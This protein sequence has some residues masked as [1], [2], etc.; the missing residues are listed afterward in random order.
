MVFTRL[1]T[2]EKE[3]FFGLLDEYFQ[4]RPE[5]FGSGSD[6]SEAPGRAGGGGSSTIST[7]SAVS[8]VQR[9]LTANPEMTSKAVSSGLARSN[10]P[11]ASAAATNP[12]VSNSVGRVAAASLA[13]S[14]GG[15]GGN[16]P[17][18]ASPPPVLPRR[19]STSMSTSS[20]NER[21][22]TSSPSSEID[23]LVTK[24]TSVFSS[25]KKNP[26]PPMAPIPPAFSAP[27][28]TFGP[29]PVRRAP[30]DSTAS[31]APA[32]TPAPS[33]PR[34]QV[35]PAAPQ[36]EV[37]EVRGEWAE[38]LYDYTGEDPGDLTIQAGSRVLVTDKSSDDW[39]TGQIEGQ[40]RGGLFPASYVKLL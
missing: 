10:N 17:T 16:A 2:Q 40:G 27:K 9:A 23:K 5:L 39:W 6:D 7:G 19:T 31:A 15:G 26:T 36:H 33:F 24:K 20:S 12:E 13:F 38:V 3:A 25:L 4:S 22:S 8:A 28:N 21:V 11:Y 29:P 34:R 35:P 14:G 30:S 18:K 37:E 1:S 32:S